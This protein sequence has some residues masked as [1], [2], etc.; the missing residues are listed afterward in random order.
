M[1]KQAGYT[2]IELAIVLAFVAA[3]AACGGIVWALV[4]F[5]AKLW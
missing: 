3:L 5:I 2:V 1:K 4:H